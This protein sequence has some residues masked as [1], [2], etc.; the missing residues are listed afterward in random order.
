M[1][2]VLEH[3][4]RLMEMGG[5]PISPYGDAFA[6]VFD[7]NES[8]TINLTTNDIA[9][10]TKI[11]LDGVEQ[12]ISKNKTAVVA[13]GNHVV[14]W[15]LNTTTLTSRVIAPID[16]YNQINGKVYNRFAFFPANFVENSYQYTFRAS[17][18]Y[19]AD[20]IYC[21]ALTPPTMPSNASFFIG[22]VDAINVPKG[23]ESAYKVATIWKN[24]ANKIIG[25]L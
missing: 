22:G 15:L 21:Y 14:T 24:Y 11:T 4:R 13:Q 10:I 7:C 3:R 12:S 5:V 23:T 1:N 20:R 6:A 2:A 16:G 18:Y 8:I 25:D 19:H 9:G 17:P